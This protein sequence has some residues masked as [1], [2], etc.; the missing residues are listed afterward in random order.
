MANGDYLYRTVGGETTYWQAMQASPS[1]NPSITST[2]WRQ[3]IPGVGRAISDELGKNSQVKVNGGD[4]V[5]SNKTSFTEDEHG[6]DGIS[7]DI[8]NVSIGAT[9]TF[10]VAKDSSRAKS[11]IDNFVTEFND[12]QDYIKSLVSVTN[13]G[14][15][16][17]SGKFSSNI[18]MPIGKPVEKTSSVNLSLTPKADHNR[19]GKR[20][21]SDETK[22]GIGVSLKLGS[23]DGGYTVKVLEDS[24]SETT[25][26]E[27]DG[28]AWQASV[29]LLIVQALEHRID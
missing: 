11:A 21:I 23:N 4:L 5:Y 8:A 20:I 25:F 12:A 7:F 24:T 29:G 28:S 14:E 27:L 1:E 9:G 10:T 16:V 15:T 2:Q 18:E 13:D 22:L 19:W 26:H 3:V 6:Y 17:T